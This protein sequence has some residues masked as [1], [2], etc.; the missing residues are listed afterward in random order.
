MFTKIKELFS[1]YTVLC[2]ITFA[3]ILRLYKI[4]WSSIWHDE[5]YTM[6]LLKYDFSEILSR[7]ARDVHPPGYYLIAKPWV[8][9]FGESVFSIR[10]LSLIFSVG[11]VY[12][13]YK[14]VEKIWSKN[15]AI[16]SSIFV[17]LSPFMIRFGQEA[18]M[19]G[20]VAF[21]TTLATY[22][23][24]L[25]IKEKKN[26]YLL[27]Y[28]A[29]MIVAMY[30]QY[31]S[32]FVVIS[33]W[34]ILSIFTDGFWTLKWKELFTKKI[35]VLNYKWWLTNIGLLAAY[36]PWFPVAYKQ[37][38]RVSDSYWIKPEWITER[39]IPNNVLQF[40]S[41]THFDAV[42]FDLAFGKLI[43]WIIVAFLLLVGFYL[44]KTK[45]YRIVSAL[46]I[47]GFLPMILV[48]TLSK[49]RTPVYQDRYFP[50]SA[51]GIFVIWGILTSE[52]KNKFLKYSFSAALIITMLVGNYIMHIDVAHQMKQMSDI[53]NQNSEGSTVVSGELYTFLDGKYYL[54]DNLKL[55][56]DGVDGYGESSLFYD[57]QN[58]YLV[59]LDNLK[60]SSNRIIVI[61]KTGDK[62]YF[63]EDKWSGFKDKVLFSE[64]KNNGLKA[65]LYYN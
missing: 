60:L 1:K 58:N 52:I 45:K 12:L 64:D 61:G 29:A 2:I 47:F 9:V 50:F 17:A 6:W 51:I 39:T 8:M 57:Q 65:V 22:M 10:F 18:R 54:G 31:Y 38:T 30:T 63:S 43:Y 32:F 59:T 56:S 40:I 44:Y 5:G 48:F 14:I 33:H 24:V 55:I 19:Y 16:W 36:A 46:Y 3:T 35:G 37:V 27:P 21:F 11:I 13:T 41:H 28:F 4:T 26:I 49:L 20:V 23:L 42:Y 34:L 62:D 25:Y 7:T 53:V 15:A